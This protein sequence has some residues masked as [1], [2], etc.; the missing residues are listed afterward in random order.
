MADILDLK[1]APWTDI[2]DVQL[3]ALQVRAVSNAPTPP[4]SQKLFLSN[5]VPPS[6]TGQARQ[7]MGRRRRRD[8]RPHRPA[9][10]A[11]LAP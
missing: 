6:R 11:T 5:H 7:P 2:E 9:V 8:A 1:G 10:R 4:A 3:S